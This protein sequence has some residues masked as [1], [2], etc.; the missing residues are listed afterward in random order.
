MESLD[1]YNI[2]IRED[3]QSNIHYALRIIRVILTSAKGPK[4]AACPRSANLPNL[5]YF[6]IE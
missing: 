5:R 6:I 1:R 3:Y 4:R 2:S